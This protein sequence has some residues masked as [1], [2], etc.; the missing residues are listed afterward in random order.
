[1]WLGFGLAFLTKGPPGLIPLLAFLV[2]LAARRDWQGL[3][4]ILMSWGVPIFLVV[5]FGWY[6]LAEARFPGLLHFLLNAEVAG[7]VATDSFR[8]NGE[9]YDALVIFLPTL[10]LGG[11]PWLPAWLAYGR[12]GHM[13][14]ALAGS[15]DGLL[16]LWIGLA[17]VIHSLAASRLPLYLLPLFAPLALWL[18]RRLEPVVLEANPRQVRWVVYACLGLM[19][20]SKMA[21]GQLSP[22]DRDAR[23]T[24]RQLSGLLQE[25]VR[26]VVAVDEKAPWEMRFYLDAQVRETW[27]RRTPYAPEFKPPRTLSEILAMTGGER[28]RVFAVNP[29]STTEFERAVRKSGSCPVKLVTIHSSSCTAHCRAGKRIVRGRLPDL[30]STTEVSP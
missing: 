4:R 6:I 19:L 27:L 29:M 2:W 24:A 15:E 30:P 26:E 9:W 13:T 11:I 16:L 25:P 7:R 17:L 8:R 18:A 14:P 12:R 5:G 10:L 3:N 23:A 21:L 1:M 28:G 22:V 20:A